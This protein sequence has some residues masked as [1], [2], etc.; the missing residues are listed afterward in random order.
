MTLKQKKETGFLDKILPSVIR[1]FSD[2]DQ[3]VQLAACDAMYN[4]LKTCK[5]GILRYKDFLDIFSSI[6]YLIEKSPSNDVKEYSKKVDENL[7][8]VVYRSLDR[9]LDFDLDKLVNR[10]CQM[11]SKSD[12][13][14]HETQLVLIRWIESLHSITNVNILSC[15]PRFLEKLFTIVEQQNYEKVKT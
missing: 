15:V 5:E 10:I 12:T 4:I 14:N 11:L 9:G 6:I 3:K 13:K 1:S 8:D 7:K 2:K